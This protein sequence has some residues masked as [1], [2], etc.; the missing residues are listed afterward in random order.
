MWCH[1]PC[2]TA[3][4]PVTHQNG[5]SITLPLTLQQCAPSKYLGH[6]KS[7]LIVWMRISLC[8]SSEC[9][10]FFNASQSITQWLTHN[11]Q[12][13]LAAT[14]D[15]PLATMALRSFKCWGTRSK[16]NHYRRSIFICVCVCMIVCGDT[17]RDR[18]LPLLLS[19]LLLLMSLSPLLL[20]F[21]WLFSHW[22]RPY[23]LIS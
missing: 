18:W 11:W 19:T 9:V 8:I 16:R 23:Q 10:L 5:N 13:P 2:C 14:C 22:P 17:S 12:A 7:Q 1:F 15:V 3:V 4:V 6:L 20:L 21:W